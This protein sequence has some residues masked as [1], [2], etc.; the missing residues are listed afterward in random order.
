MQFCS[1]LIILIYN[2]F[3]VLNIL[4]AKYGFDDHNAPPFNLIEPCCR[5]LDEWLSQ[6]EEFIACVHCKAGK[7][8]LK[9]SFNVSCED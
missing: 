1:I 3:F 5:D 4:V 7:V 6:G 8:S 2:N 9:S